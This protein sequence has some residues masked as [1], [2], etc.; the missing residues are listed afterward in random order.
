[1]RRTCAWGFCAHRPLLQSLIPIT[2]LAILL[3]ASPLSAQTN[4]K[5]KPPKPAQLDAGISFERDKT[6]GELHL[7]QPVAAQPASPP[8]EPHPLRV[9]VNLVPINCN[10]FSPD[11]S[12]V[13]GLAREDFRLFQD[14]IEQHI[15]YFDAGNDPASVALVIDASPSVLPDAHAVQ[16]AARGLAD[17][18]APRDEVAVVEFSA[19]SYVLAPFSRDHAQLES[20]IAHVNVRALFGDTGGS[21]I[22]E[23]VYLTAQKLF[24][25][26]TGRKAI[27]LLT[28]GEDNGLGLTIATASAGKDSGAFAPTLKFDDVVRGLAAEGVEVY[29]VSTQN[30]PKVL[31]DDWLAAHSSRTLLTEEARERGIPAYTLFLAELVRRAGGGLYFLREAESSRDAFEKIAGNIRT[32]YTLGFYP[33]GE[34][35]AAPGWHALRVEAASKSKLRVVNRAAYYVP[36][37]A[38]Q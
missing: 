4:Q 6:S 37:K 15:A 30:R 27:L 8:G 21:N 34:N 20:A 32:Q 25:G 16:D 26:R 28:D 13:A 24:R 1:M 10:V 14:G 38:P 29:A 12:S 33:A 5:P 36:G 18:L 11:G 31:T 35:A 9:H 19:H 23:T 22:Y 2:G 7:A 17:A 3:C